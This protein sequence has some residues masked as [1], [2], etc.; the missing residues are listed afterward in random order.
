MSVAG[1]AMSSELVQV[2]W[3]AIDEQAEE[4]VRP[5]IHPDA[6][7]EMAMAEQNPVA[8]RDAVMDVLRD[9]WTGVHS[10]T[11]T[12]IHEVSPNRVIVVGRSRHPLPTG[13]FADSQ[14]SWLCE[15]RSGC[16][17]GSGCSAISRRHEQQQQRQQPN[18]I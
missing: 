7:L 3:L 1:M 11:A 4:R 12:E 13:G 2:L 18:P 15:W 16:S 14:V 9:A 10:L 5:L 17:T 8:G 6:T